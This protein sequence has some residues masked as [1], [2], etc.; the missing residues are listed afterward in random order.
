MQKVAFSSAQAQ[1][2]VP[3]E[4][5][6]ARGHGI[7]EQELEGPAN[8][9]LDIAHRDLA[10]GAAA[11]GAAGH[12]CVIQTPAVDV[13]NHLENVVLVFRVVLSALLYPVI[14]RGCVLVVIDQG[15][16][17]AGTRGAVEALFLHEPAAEV[18]GPHDQQHEE[19][20]D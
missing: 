2:G 8:V 10:A 6:S 13:R 15:I 11:T 14:E 12:D 16:L 7:V 18:V 17:R 1:F 20:N 5:H 9:D 4:R 3:L 19:G